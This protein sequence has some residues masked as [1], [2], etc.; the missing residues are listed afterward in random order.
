MVINR[1]PGRSLTVAGTALFFGV[2]GYKFEKFQEIRVK[3][4]KIYT[5]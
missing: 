5:V 3:S 4:P 2:L 1:F